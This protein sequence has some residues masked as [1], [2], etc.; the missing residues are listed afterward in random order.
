MKKTISLF[1]IALT[2]ILIALFQSNE[3]ASAAAGAYDTSFNGT[4]SR[5]VGAGLGTDVGRAVAIQPDG[6]I[7]VAGKASNGVDEDFAVA[8]YNADGSLDTTFNGSGTVM[9]RVLGGNDQANAVAIQADGKI[10]AAGQASSDFA[11]VRYNADGTLDTT[12]SGDGKLTTSLRSGTDIANSVVIQ[13]DGK[14]VVAGSASNGTN[15]RYG[16][17][18]YNTDGTLDTTFELDGIV[19]TQ[20][21]TNADFA[22][23]L[24]IQPDGLLVAAGY[25]D[26]GTDY[27]FSA[28]RYNTDGSLDTTFDTDGK[29]TT[30]VL[31][32]G[33]VATSVAL[34]TDGKLVLAGYAY[35]GSANVF[36]AV[37]YNSN[38][39][40][41]TS[42]SGD[43]KQTTN[44]GSIDDE[45]N[46]VVV[47][48][49]GRIILAGH[50]Y[51]GNTF[52]F[53]LVRYTTAG[54]LDTNYD[55]DGKVTTSV[56]INDNIAY[57]IKLQSDGKAIVAGAGDATNSDFALA[58]YNTNGSLDGAFNT[59]GTVATDIGNR[60]NRYNAVARQTDGKIVAGGYA[61]NGQND[62]FAVTRLNTDGSLDTTFGGTGKVLTPVLASNDVV[63]AVAI[64]SDGKI[65]AA[66]SALNG[67]TNDFA[68]VRY[69][70]DGTLDT[71]F[72][73]D[74][75]VVTSIIFGDDVVTSMAVQSDGKIVVAGYSIG[76]GQADSYVLRYNTNGSLD[77]SFSADGI[78][79]ISFTGLND[80]AYSVAIQSDGKIVVGGNTY[81]GSNYD[82]A[83]VRVNSNG[84]LDTTFN[85]DG[86][87]TFS[88]LAGNDTIYSIAIQPDGKIVVAGSAHNGTNED[89]A[90]ARVTTDGYLDT[91]WNATGR[92]TTPVLAG[93]D[94]AYAVNVQWDGKIV[95]AGRASVGGQTD[96]AIVRYTSI[97][98]L[99]TTFNYVSSPLGTGIQ[100]LDVSAGT[101]DEARA[102]TIDPA[103]R[104][105][106]AGK[107]G[108]VAGVVRLFGDNGPTAAAV[109][110]AG[111][112]STAEGSGLRGA[113]ITMT[114]QSGNTRVT[115][116]SSFGYYH[117]EGV[118]AGQTYVVS[119]ASKRFQYQP[120]IVQL[121]DDLFDLDFV[122]EP[123]L[124]SKDRRLPSPLNHYKP[125]P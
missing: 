56:L 110:I 24:V 115:T 53:A 87:L 5:V 21:L 93:N 95:V 2:S 41:D 64:Q 10:V 12:F 86:L 14:I 79:N 106:L 66:G 46:S 119:V 101:D 72:D 44:F 92:V 54:A 65:L 67:A 71:T 63:N 104:I 108:D 99:D 83:V 84:T 40:L 60:P 77:T 100:T 122:A 81:N 113:V 4:G 88:M 117:F 89:F 16:L 62:D 80:F 61:S 48:A 32:A 15:T 69:N 58:R 94:I 73:T 96:L 8:R 38:G 102:M 23:A 47:Q 116:S 17:V 45:A 120:R 121:T 9:T 25:S 107:I 42:F 70:T 82:F 74:G 30:P 90:V 59:T 19:I 3:I 123:Q 1:V 55:G 43:G 49:N 57:G 39:S 118:A 105:I 22:K 76:S 112:V 50:S 33:D 20:V 35:D 36:A 98:N 13:S 91:F 11:V 51:N 52:D 75:K 85:L 68:I 125:G 124:E 34:Q 103:N 26:N 6:K 78:F 97:G 37:R 28:V 18:R 109:S 114:D 27:D 31:S 111:R 29:V 7:V